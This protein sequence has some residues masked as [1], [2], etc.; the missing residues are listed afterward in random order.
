MY[1]STVTN[2]VQVFFN[3]DNSNPDNRTCT[4]LC[5]SCSKKYLN[6]NTTRG[7][8]YLN[9]VKYRLPGTFG[10]TLMGADLPCLPQM[11]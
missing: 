7:S 4:V 2:T 1:S 3:S 10:M 8:H 6:T 11:G 5:I 9:G